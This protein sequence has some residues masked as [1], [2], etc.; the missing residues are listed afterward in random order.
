MRTSNHGPAAGVSRVLAVL[1]LALALPPAPGLSQQAPPVPDTPI[2]TGDVIH[3]KVWREPDWN[4]DFLVDQ[5]GVAALPLVG[6]VQVAGMTQRALKEMLR[7]AFAREIHE[8]Q[9]QVLVMK[10]IRVLGEVRNPG[11]FTLDPT[12]SVADAL[13]VAGGRGELGRADRVLLRRSG[14]TLATNVLVDTRLAEL[15]I[16][17]GDELSVPER[18]WISRNGGTL[19]G[20]SVGI[21]GLM[22]ALLVR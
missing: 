5:F 20:T 8:P 14:E 16:Q 21:L 18:S 6:D 4:G 10:R 3:L 17:T 9:L 2:L 22:T 7:A 12:M 1:A 11:V 13:A 19:L 15:A